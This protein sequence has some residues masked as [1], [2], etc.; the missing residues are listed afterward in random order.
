VKSLKDN[1]CLFTNN[2]FESSALRFTFTDVGIVNKTTINIKNTV[3]T[4][5]LTYNPF[6]LYFQL[7]IE[8]DSPLK[9][10]NPTVNI[11]DC[12][13][14]NAIQGAVNLNYY[15]LIKSTIFFNNTL[16]FPMNRAAALTLKASIL[17]IYCTFLNNSAPSYE[18]SAIKFEQPSSDFAFL[19]VV[20]Y[21]RIVSGNYPNAIDNTVFIVSNNHP[22]KKISMF[23]S[24][25]SME[26]L[27]NQRF[28]YQTFDNRYFVMKCIN[29]DGTSYNALSGRGKFFYLKKI[30]PHVKN[31]ICYKCPYQASCVNGI[32]SKGNYWGQARSEISS[33][34]FVVLL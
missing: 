16:L 21:T 3:F 11:V 20:I 34:S 15:T 25:F 31:N 12:T 27:K 23:L 9:S 18:A 33:L 17:L 4:K 32:K 26:C 14:Q 1:K 8:G 13:F 6:N 10:I 22:N 5:S 28:I 19:T 24:S 30:V 7:D 2:L 29:C